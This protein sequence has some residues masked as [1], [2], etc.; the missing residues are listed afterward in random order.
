MSAR[1]Y[2]PLL[3]VPLDRCLLGRIVGEVREERRNLRRKR[4]EGASFSFSR[5]VARANFA[6]PKSPKIFTA[7]LLLFY[8]SERATIFA[9][10]RAVSGCVYGCFVSVAPPLCSYILLSYFSFCIVHRSR[11]D[12]QQCLYSSS[13]SYNGARL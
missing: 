4:A 2:T 12:K 10:S 13:S 11:I 5:S 9:A 6:C 8:S 7:A 3:L 1:C